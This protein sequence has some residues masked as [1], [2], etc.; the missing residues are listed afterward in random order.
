SSKASQAINATH[1]FLY[2]TVEPSR[3]VTADLLLPTTARVEGALNASGRFV[4]DYGIDEWSTR[5]ANATLNV[6]ETLPNGTASSS[7]LAWYPFAP[8]APSSAP[9]TSLASLPKGRYATSAAG[10]ATAMF[11]FGGCCAPGRLGDIVKFDPVANT[12]T[13]VS[14]LPSPRHG[15]SAAWNGTHAFAF[16]GYD[17]NLLDQIVRFDPATNAVTV[18]G[19]KLPAAGYGTVAVANGTKLYVFGAGNRV[20]EYE[21]TTDA[22]TVKAP[23][24]VAWPAAA[25]HAGSAYVLG[26]IVSGAA[27]SDIV[28]YDPV[29]DTVVSMQGR[30]P[31][32]RYGAAAVS[33]GAYVYV[34]G[35]VGAE[36]EIVRYDPVADE[37]IPMY[38]GAL[39]AN[40]SLGG[41]VW[42]NDSAYLLGGTSSAEPNQT[43][44]YRPVLDVATDHRLRVGAGV[45][46]EL[47]SLTHAA[48]YVF[49]LNVTDEYGTR[50][51]DR[52]SFVSDVALPRILTTPA[53]VLFAKED[54]A[55]SWSVSDNVSGLKTVRLER[56]ASNLSWVPIANV[57]AATL[58]AANGTAWLNTTL[59]IAGLD[60]G[61]LVP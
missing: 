28:R 57:S 24:T 36:R 53:D 58:P 2:A 8:P 49:D 39:P 60:N 61:T 55:L 43:L 44:R 56:Q 17:G 4:V 5:V 26:G 47:H 6:T 35:G 42:A 30:L 31:S 1:S 38:W 23:I 11:V 13:T 54:L 9:V 51:T 46:H 50:F 33:D 45:S 16:G 19:G 15:T 34:L 25:W 32:P 59:S 18:M 52:V 14:A 27:S 37:A 40:R 21:T 7:M 20:L 22:A 3:L 10:N 12:T 48:G 29:T 41:V